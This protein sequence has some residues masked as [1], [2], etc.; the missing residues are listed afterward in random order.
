LPRSTFLDE[1][2]EGELPP[3]VEIHTLAA[4]RDWVCPLP[5]TRLRGANAVT[6]PLGHSSLVV[7][8]MVYE[9]ILAIL[10]P[11]KAQESRL[12]NLRAVR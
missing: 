3:G 9:R 1:L 5:S 7:S 2:A 12:A 8:P 4:V 6:V 11:G 10:R